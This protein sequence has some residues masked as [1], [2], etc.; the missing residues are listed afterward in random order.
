MIYIVNQVEYLGICNYAL[1]NVTL[2][3]TMLSMLEASM[4]NESLLMSSKE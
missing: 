2:L 1:N 3:Q 4:A